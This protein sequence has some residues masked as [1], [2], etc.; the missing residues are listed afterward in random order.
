[1]LIYRLKLT[2]FVFQLSKLIYYHCFVNSTSRPKDATLYMYISDYGN[3]RNALECPKLWFIWIGHA[4]SHA[5]M[6]TDIQTDRCCICLR[7]AC[8]YDCVS[9]A[10]FHVGSW[11][12]FV[13]CVC[14]IRCDISQL[15]KDYINILLWCRFCCCFVIYVLFPNLFITILLKLLIYFEI[16]F[17]PNR[18]FLNS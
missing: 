3:F 2:N 4:C 6:Q 14:T 7:A 9:V 12:P 18:F 11:L 15:S 16:V 17:P 13:M 1:M 10:I 8:H 5:D